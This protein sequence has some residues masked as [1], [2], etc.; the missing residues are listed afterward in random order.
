M[1]VLERLAVKA[2]A[3][4]INRLADDVVVLVLVSRVVAGSAQAVDLGRCHAEEDDV[5]V[6]TAS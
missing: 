4:S 5:V 2:L 6:A 3:E 1:Q